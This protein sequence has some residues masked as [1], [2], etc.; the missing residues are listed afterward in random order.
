MTTLVLPCWSRVYPGSAKLFAAPTSL[1]IFFQISFLY[2]FSDFASLG[3][4]LSAYCFFLSQSF[5]ALHFYLI[6][7]ERYCL[8]ASCQVISRAASEGWIFVLRANCPQS[9]APLLKNVILLTRS[10]PIV[11]ST[12]TLDPGA[13]LLLYLLYLLCV[14]SLQTNTDSAALKRNIDRRIWNKEICISFFG[15]AD[16]RRNDCLLLDTEV[17]VSYL[18]SQTYKMSLIYWR[19]FSLT[20]LTKLN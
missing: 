17:I 6:F 10:W 14:H 7:P 12:C 13:Q 9:P 3:P 5:S 8:L 19:R 16:L 2:W 1:R 11:C 4:I 18:A 15:K 20:V